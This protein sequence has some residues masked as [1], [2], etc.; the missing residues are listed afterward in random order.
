MFKQIFLV[1][2]LYFALQQMAHSAIR[3]F[4]PGQAHLTTDFSF[5]KTTKNFNSL[6]GE[7]DSLAAGHYY[8][9]VQ[10][11]PRLDW[12]L[13][14]HWNIYALADLVNASSDNNSFKRTRTGF[15][16]LHLGAQLWIQFQKIVLI[17]EVKLS[18]PI[19]SYDPSTDEVF[20]SDGVY[21]GLLG[22]N[23]QTQWGS[24][25]PLFN[26]FYEYRAE[27]LSHRF[28]YFAQITKIFPRRFKLSAHV[29]GHMSLFD[30]G[31]TGTPSVRTNI[32][33]RVNGSSFAHHGINPQKLSAGGWVGLYT[34]SNSIISLGYEL[35]LNGKN[36]SK[37]DTVLL[38]WEWL[39]VLKPKS[40]KRNLHN[41][42]QP[43]DPNE[44]ESTPTDIFDKVKQ[45]IEGETE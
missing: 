44:E 42:F 30:D 29:N 37:N 21:K 3:V 43:V 36:A 39:Q 26:G 8:Q 20:L 15:S 32:N 22:A 2:F 11:S 12:N 17:P 40:S 33:N 5:Y 10:L 9:Q 25:I 24:W 31:N 23:I 1:I 41:S 16:D 7:I 45:E 38:K 35:D 28:L 19:T 34:T 14:S 27:D 18:V 4:K 13:N 6:G